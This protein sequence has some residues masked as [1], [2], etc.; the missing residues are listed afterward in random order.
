MA[1][2]SAGPAKGYYDLADL[3]EDDRIKLAAHHVVVHG[4]VVGVTVDDDPAKVARYHRKL[5][6][7]GCAILST[8]K[9]PVEGVVTIRVGPRTPRSSPIVQ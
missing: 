8:E 4:R 2:K 3:P 1:K 9:G 7:R 6:S 5:L